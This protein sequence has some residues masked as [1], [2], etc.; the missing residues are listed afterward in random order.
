MKTK[1][2][3]IYNKYVQPSLDREKEQKKSNRAQWWYNNWISLLGVFFA[4][5]AALPV[6]IQGFETILK[7]LK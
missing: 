2:K 5:I 7:W 6:I 3:N 4:F 1:D